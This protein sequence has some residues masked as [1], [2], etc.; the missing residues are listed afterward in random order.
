MLGRETQEGEDVAPHVAAQRRRSRR[1]AALAGALGTTVLATL[2]AVMMGNR[3]PETNIETR[4]PDRV[5]RPGSDLDQPPVPS[6]STIV[7][8]GTPTTEAPAE[9]VALTGTEVVVLDSD[10][11]RRLRL[12]AHH[13]EAESTVGV[14]L[15]GVALN[16]DRRSAYYALAGD[17]GTGTVYRV[18]VD[19]GSPP[20]QVANGISPALSPDGAKLA[21]AAPGGDGP[22]GRPRCNNRIVVRDLPTGA[23]RTWRYPDDEAHSDGL[24]QDGAITKIAWAP[25]STRLAYTLSFEGDS[26]AVLDTALDRDLSETLE[27]VVPGGGGDSRHPAWQA[28]SGRL[29]IV[30]SAFDCCYADSYTG[31]ARTLLVDPELKLSQNLLPPGKKPAWLDFDATGDHLLYVDGGSLYRRTRS[32]SPMVVGRGYVAADW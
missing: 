29:A 20:E 28:T 31:P 8:A 16:P 22:D 32:G 4:S 3:G 10:T 5:A 11:G 26:V 24:Y 18:P 23:E 1:K 15:E 25:D 30:N 19:G 2:L 17:C 14:F 12:L 27:V 21:Y 13:P 6:D 7:K 9:I